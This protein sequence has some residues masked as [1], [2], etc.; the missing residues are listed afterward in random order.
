MFKDG[1]SDHLKLKLVKVNDLKKG[2]IDIILNNPVVF[3]FISQS[4]FEQVL[5]QLLNRSVTAFEEVQRGVK[6]A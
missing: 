3:V 1:N 4:G 6:Y 2:H 5:K